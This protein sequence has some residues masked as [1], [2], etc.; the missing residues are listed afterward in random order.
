MRSIRSDQRRAKTKSQ[1]LTK[2][3]TGEYYVDPATI[4]EL[5][6]IVSATSSNQM[7]KFLE[8][9]LTKKEL[10]NITRRI[11]IAKMILANMTYEEISAETKASKSTLQL[12]KQSLYENEGLLGDII[13][14][15]TKIPRRSAPKDRIDPTT[16]YF[17]RR[18]RKGK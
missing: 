3:G 16:L 5:S 17:Q 8:A 15:H 2:G 13:S 14:R 12:V 18:I 1:A 4:K 9:L 10:V 7:E 6:R 11:A